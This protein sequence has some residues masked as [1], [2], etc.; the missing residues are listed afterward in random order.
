MT[1]TAG[2]GWF[3]LQVNG[4]AGVDF[5]A[6]DLDGDAL[7]RACAVLRADGVAGILATVIT[8]DLD[9]M[10]A[11]LRRIAALRAQD[12]LARS[13]VA[14]LHVEGPFL[15]PEP[16]FAGAH[17]R[18]RMQ[19]ATPDAAARL[20][21]AGEGLVRLVT[22]AP[23]RDPGC[24]T[25]RALFDT[26]VT[27]AAGHTD[28]H[29]RQLEAAID[30]GL[31]GFTHLGNG[32]PTTLPRHDNIVQR[33]LSLSDRLWIAFVGDGVHVPYFALRNYLKVTTLSRAAIVTDAISAAGLGPGT[34]SL[35]DQQVVV[36]ADGMP[37]AADG[38]HFAGSTATMPTMAAGLRDAL[39]LSAE[40]LARLCRDNPRR[41]IGLD[42]GG[43]VRR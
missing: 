16:G 41:A 42:A 17:P 7:H 21:E 3:D 38:E 32:C 12:P 9:R 37:R 4:Y 1:E 35:G 30:A 26:G 5:N 29:R 27:V 15:S 33:V 36:G 25:V 31:T 22:L 6:D 19:D 18:E 13:V 40:D 20:L 23:E 24:A 2:D 11:R 8:D 43:E 34:Y 14:G 28:A 10:A 39:G